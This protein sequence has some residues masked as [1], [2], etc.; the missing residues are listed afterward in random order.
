[1]NT[2]TRP[3]DLSN[4]PAVGSLLARHGIWL[5]KQRGQHLLVN[6]DILDRIVKAAGLGPESQVLEVGPGIGTLTVA[7]SQVASR[8]VA[9]EIDRRMIGVLHETVT[10]PN[11]DIVEGDALEIDPGPL[12]A[13]Y[14]YVMVAN[15]PY[16]IATPLIR[17]LLN[18]PAD[19]RPTELVVMVQREVARRMAAQPG[20]LS[21]LGVAVQLLADVELLFDVP[22]ESFFPPP[23]VMSSVVRLRPL[24]GYRVP[25]L[26][27]ETRFFQTVTA[28]FGNKR[29]Q[30]HNALG[31][32]GV[33]TERIVA[34]LAAA[35]VDTHRRAE[36]LTLAEWSALSAAL[37]GA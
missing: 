32:L 16:G 25:P 20:D 4:P 30:L 9:I 18:A 5:Q 23:E 34:A 21:L 14:P 1:M 10:A 15:L 24:P 37:W 19:R 11:V 33:G 29:K 35:Q 7:L 36:T 27:S 28:G 3:V 13:G 31:T 26:P 12:F 17:R 22:P 6:R 8:V 2:A